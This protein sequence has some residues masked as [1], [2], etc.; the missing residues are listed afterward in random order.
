MDVI[1]ITFI[2]LLVIT[3]LNTTKRSF[4]V[5]GVILLLGYA[6][7]KMLFRR[8]YLENPPSSRLAEVNADIAYLK[9]VGLS[10][11]SDNETMRARVAERAQ[12]E[13]ATSPPPSA[14]LL[15][16]PAAAPL[17]DQP[18]KPIAP[19][20]PPVPAMKCSIENFGSI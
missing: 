8:E 13:K 16:Q 1:D 2:V 14:P 20:L 6:A 3:L 11:D 19:S 12:L 9:S 10:E 15:D 5:W 7:L 17:R 18:A 4:L